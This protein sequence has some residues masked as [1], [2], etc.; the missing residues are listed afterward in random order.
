MKKVY[1]KLR[2]TFS[3]IFVAIAIL[4]LSYFTFVSFYQGKFFPGVKIANMDVG[5][6]DSSITQYNLTSEFKKR[7]TSTINLNYLNQTFNIDLNTAVPASNLDDTIVKAASAGRSGNILLDLQTQLKLL[8]VGENFTPELTF[9]NK[10]Q[11]LSSINIINQQIKK[12]AIPAQLVFADTINVIP[13]Q[14]GS[15][16]DSQ[17]LL[18]NIQKYLILGTN[19]PLI[20]PTKTL[21]PNLTTFKAEKYKKALDRVKTNPIKLT[22]ENNSWTIDQAT[23]YSLLDFDKTTTQVLSWENGEQTFSIEAIS[24]GQTKLTDSQLLL[25]QDLLHSYLKNIAEKI[26]QPLKEAKF[27]YDESTNRVREFEPGQTGKELNIAKTTTLISKA[28]LDPTITTIT[29]PVETTNPVS[30]A[31]QVN[32]YGISDLLGTGTSSFVDSIPNRVFNIGLAATRINGILVPPGEVFSFDAYL[33]V[34]TAA[35]GFKQAYVIKEGKTVL[36]DGGGVCQVSTTLFRAALNA[37]LPI[38]ERTAHAYRVGFYEQ[39][40]SPPGMDATVYPPYVDLKFKNDTG[41]YI[42]IQNYMVG[43]TLTY[44]IY[45]TSDGRVTTVGK[46]VIISQ[47]APPPELRKDDPTLAKGTER[48]AE[49]AIWGMNIQFARTVTRNGETL[50]NEVIRSNF[51]PW[52][53]V[54]LVGTKE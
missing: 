30:T 3:L 1:H 6:Q 9:K 26:D 48:E 28:V 21:Q 22:F 20:I 52:Q 42:L 19:A 2:L 16:L 53:K 13:S 25:D 34:V 14:D 4:L 46:P 38:V 32:N 10:A 47:T 23:L 51:R 39:G 18:N 31:N 43:T 17:K 54:T 44:K 37:G 50:I 35:T 24:F 11:L 41:G 33:G 7:S 40:G 8:I 27:L 12:E 49:H 45:G 29:L 15:E 36:D 5:G